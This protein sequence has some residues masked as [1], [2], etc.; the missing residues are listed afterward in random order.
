M[1][2]LG[3]TNA[4]LKETQDA[5]SI[6]TLVDA[7][8]DVLQAAHW[9]NTSWV[10]FQ[11]QRLW[12]FRWTEGSIPVVNGK[13]QY[14]YDDLS[15]TEGIVIV[16]DSFYAPEGLPEAETYKELRDRRRAAAS[17]DT[18]K[19]LRVAVRNHNTVETYPDIDGPQTLSFDYYA[20]AQQLTEDAD[21]PAGLPEDF[22]MLI[23]HYALF[24]YGAD[25]GGQEGANQYA[26]H[27]G[28][29]KILKNNYSSLV[30]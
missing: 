24:R 7:P 10:E 17:V 27:G 19:V 14:T 9:I 6:S 3:L 1:D 11:T 30:L 26:S 5:D 8:D 21:V 12:P 18:S 20:A 4:F 22:H 15:L 29:Y 13:T 2:Y 25:I 28:L 23:V 16:E